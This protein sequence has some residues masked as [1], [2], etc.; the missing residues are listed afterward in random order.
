MEDYQWFMGIDVS[1]SKLDITLL[2]GSEKRHYSVIENNEKSIKQFIK[3]L[4]AI[5]GFSLK[6]CL[7]CMEHTGIYNAHL[8]TISKA[9]AWNLCLES[10]IQIKQ[11]GGLQ[12]GKNDIIDSYRIALYAYKNKSFLKLWEAP[13]EVILKLKKLSGVRERLL[14][15]K[16][17]LERT[18]KEDKHFQSKHLSTF[19]G[20]CCAKSIKAIEGDIKRTE[21]QIQL[22]I[23]SDEELTRLFSIIES[24]PGVGRISATE[25]VITTNEFKNIH[26]AR[27]YACYAGVA[28]FEHSSGSSIR[29]KTRIS[30]KANLKVKTRLHMASLVAAMHCEELRLYYQRKVEEGKNKM[31]VLNAVRNKLVHRIFAC[32]KENRLYEKNYAPKFV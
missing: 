10:A 16:V 1:K 9:Q 24:V 25:I 2:E 20:K 3:D 32:V 14:Q 23:A 28:P 21:E 7:V 19:L 27:K 6:N 15:A 30:K 8:L 31:C 5:A 29:G 26:D 4:T 11:S 22:V 17:Q 13:R 12:R 18:L